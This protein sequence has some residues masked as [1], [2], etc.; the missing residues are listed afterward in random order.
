MVFKTQL[1]TALSTVVNTVLDQTNSNLQRN[2]SI[3]TTPL[4]YCSSL[5]KAELNFLTFPVWKQICTELFLQT[6]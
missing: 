2:L 5:S 6:P 1:D 4:L 3:T